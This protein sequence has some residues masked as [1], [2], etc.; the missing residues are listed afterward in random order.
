MGGVRNIH[1]QHHER[2]SDRVWRMTTLWNHWGTKVTT[3][4]PGCNHKAL[5]FSVWPFQM[6]LVQNG[7]LLDQPYSPPHMMVSVK[8]KLRRLHKLILNS[9]YALE[10]TSAHVSIGWLGDLMYMISCRRVIML[11]ELDRE[12]GQL[13]VPTKPGPD[14]EHHF[15]SYASSLAGPLGYVEVC[16]AEE[17]YLVR[18]LEALKRDPDVRGHT[19]ELVMNL[20]QQTK[21]SLKE[22]MYLRR[23]HPSLQV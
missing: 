18:E 14:V 12:L 13:H 19:R 1:P 20:L 15:D 16:E 4:D 22:I 21:A 2:I 8:K 9:R 10:R 5:I 6:R 11:T 23:N 7:L 3:L 17:T